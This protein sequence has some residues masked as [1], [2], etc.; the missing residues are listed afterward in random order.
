MGISIKNTRSADFCVDRIGV[1]TNFAVISNVV[2]KR[3]HCNN[4]LFT[5]INSSKKFA[6]KKQCFVLQQ[7]T[8]SEYMSYESN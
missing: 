7:F 1:I 4:K 8:V 2:I 5:S 3:V 6:C